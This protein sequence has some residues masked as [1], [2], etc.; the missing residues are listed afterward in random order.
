MF[1]RFMEHN[2]NEALQDTPVVKDNK[3]LS[4]KKKH[5]NP[6][7]RVKRSNPGVRS[8]EFWVA[9]LRSQ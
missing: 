9:S 7:L 1:K 3:S 6:S 2:I 5:P 4:R 8:T